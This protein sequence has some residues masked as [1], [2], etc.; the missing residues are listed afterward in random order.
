[1]VER[2]SAVTTY[3]TFGGNAREAMSFYAACLGAELQVLPFPDDNE[4]AMHACVSRNGV[5]LLMASDTMKGDAVQ[6][7]NNFSICI[8]CDSM[9]EIQRLFAAFGVEGKVHM[10]LQDMFWGAHYGDLT[11]QFGVRWLFNYQLP[12]G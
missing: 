4:R 1:M 11:D 3:L 12:K 2:M 10:P 7:G 5:S 6:A 8:G 9:E